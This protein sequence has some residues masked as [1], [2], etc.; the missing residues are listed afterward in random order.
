MWQKIS[1]LPIMAYLAIT[2]FVQD[3]KKDEKGLEVVQVVLIVLIGV[4]LV[5]ILMF[6]LREWLAELWARITGTD[7]DTGPLTEY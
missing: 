3:F 2:G 4:I 7:V 6:L 5:A 1:A